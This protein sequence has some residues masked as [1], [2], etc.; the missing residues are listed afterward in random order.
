MS[1]RNDDTIYSLLERLSSRQIN[2]LIIHCK[3]LNAG[4]EIRYLVDP[5]DLQNY[6]FPFGIE[7]E[8]IE[9]LQRIGE[10]ADNTLGL[11][12]IF[13]NPAIKL[14]IFN[15]YS[16]EILDFEWYVRQSIEKQSLA[17]DAFWSA[18]NPKQLEVGSQEFFDKTNFSL[19]MAVSV[20]LYHEG[21]QKITHLRESIRDKRLVDE[22]TDYSDPFFDTASW[23][24]IF[25]CLP[26][27]QFVDRVQEYLMS[28]TKIPK[29]FVDA[30]QPPLWFRREYKAKYRDSK[31]VDR[32]LRINEQ[33]HEVNRSGTTEKVLVAYLSSTNASK[34]LFLQPFIQ[35]RFP[36]LPLTE[37][38]SYFNPLRTAEQLFL[39]H[40]CDDREDKA[41]TLGNLE[42]VYR[43]RRSQEVSGEY[44]PALLATVSG[45]MVDR[46][47]VSRR[48]SRN[49]SLLDNIE[50][51]KQETEALANRKGYEDQKDT[52][53]CKRMSQ[54]T[55]RKYTNRKRNIS[56]C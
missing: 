48:N 16:E 42:M 15:E 53:R 4:Y 39:L 12:Y 26:D 18:F 21:L 43:L 3:V 9:D 45:W 49:Y 7:I 6:C 19:L 24:V 25:N 13:D 51:Y 38:G 14:I 2:D 17:A 44:D 54:T 8:A 20:V 27:L 5:F 31:A 11:H 34:D 32:A 30:V 33:L 46:L 1:V 56:V 35:E 36:A 41:S 22:A 37:Q 55:G 40:L 50:Q 52:G 29:K 10:K 47:D 23:T 28:S